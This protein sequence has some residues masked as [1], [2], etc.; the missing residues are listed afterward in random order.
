MSY[1][2]K[3]RNSWILYK[4]YYELVLRCYTNKLANQQ[5]LDCCSLS[6]DSQHSTTSTP[7]FLQ[8]MPAWIYYIFYFNLEKNLENL[9]CSH[10]VDVEPSPQFYRKS[11][12]QLNRANCKKSKKYDHSKKKAKQPQSKNYHKARHRYA[13]KHLR[14]SRQQKEYCKRLAYSV[15]QSN[16][17]VAYVDAKRRAAG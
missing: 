16:D 5:G 6:V 14:V 17:L 8:F 11:E 1:E 4:F 2:Y 9:M 12:K 7:T 10:Q 15:I 3:T 13:R